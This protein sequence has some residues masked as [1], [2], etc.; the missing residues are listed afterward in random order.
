MLK[1]KLLEW[2]GGRDAE[3]EY[4]RKIYEGEREERLRLQEIILRNAHLVESQPQVAVESSAPRP[5]VGL[6]SWTRAQRRL[7]RIG[8]ELARKAADDRQRYWSEKVKKSE[9]A[10]ELEHAGQN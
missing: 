3:V 1:E 4:L 9:E 10:G 2:L 7:E 5:V 6:H 8:I